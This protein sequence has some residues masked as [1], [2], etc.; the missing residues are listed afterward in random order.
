PA[1]PLIASGH[2]HTRQ[3]FQLDH[4][5]IVHC[6]STERT[7]Y[8]ERDE[9]K[10]YV[11]W[12]LERSARWRHVDLPARPM[13]WITH[14]DQIDE[15]EAGA[16]AAAPAGASVERSLYKSK[17]QYAESMNSVDAVSGVAGGTL[18]AAE[19]KK[20]DLPA[21][22][23]EK[24]EKEL[25]EALRAKGAEREKIQKQLNALGSKRQSF[26]SEKSAGNK[27][28]LDQAVLNA[29]RSQASKFGFTF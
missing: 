12:E 15:A 20:D 29:V 7:S 21:E 27:D 13:A 5:T 22:L 8:N 26:L 11:L 25:E 16:L 2:I 10:G 17:A 23:R 9:T 18:K 1:T 24:D 6:G 19:L 28:S 14:P 3:A 4:A